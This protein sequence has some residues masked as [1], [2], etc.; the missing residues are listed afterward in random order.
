MLRHLS[1]LAIAFLL[2]TGL[3]ALALLSIQNVTPVAL[4]FL[5]FRSIQ[6]PV[7]I[8]LVFCVATGLVV[9]ALLPMVSGGKRRPIRASPRDLDAFEFDD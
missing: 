4:T 1:Q 8:L 6:L 7:G 9:G 5:A 3:T 2:A